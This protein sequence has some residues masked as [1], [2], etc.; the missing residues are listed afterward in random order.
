MPIEFV[1]GSVFD[2]KRC[3][4]AHGV[5]LAGAMGKGIALQFARRY[6]AMVPEYQAWCRRKPALGSVLLWR[7]PQM[8]NP[9]F[10]LATQAHWRGGATLAAVERG[11]VNMVTMATDEYLVG[12]AL[13]W[14]GC[15]LGGLRR[16]DVRQ[17]LERV[18]AETEVRLVVCDLGPD[19]KLDSSHQ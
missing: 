9:V 11:L 10:N 1:Q 18:A 17:V 12:V 8:Q 13:P 3:A 16:S 14:I 4:F 2:Q 5:N 15:G 6:P 7:P 19:P